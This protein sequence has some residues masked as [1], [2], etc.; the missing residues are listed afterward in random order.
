MVDREAF[1]RCEEAL[2]DNKILAVAPEGTRSKTGQM[3][4]GKP[5]VALLAL[6]SGAP[7]LPVGFYGHED[8][9]LNFKHLRRT[10]FH[11]KTGKPFRLNVP[12]S[13]LS[14]RD[15][16]QR[17]TDEMMYKI[18]EQLPEK[19]RGYYAFQ[20]KIEYKYLVDDDSLLTKTRDT[21]GFRTTPLAEA[22]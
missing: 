17:V 21:A 12:L 19:Y 3:L 4:P 11:M 1:R 16:R 6:R 18:A 7:V 14:D 13:S 10:N 5:G 22:G 8:F 20:S 15:V 2:R 9:W